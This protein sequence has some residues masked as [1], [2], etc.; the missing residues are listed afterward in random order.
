MEKNEGKRLA[1]RR[2][3][4]PEEFIDWSIL[5]YEDKDTSD[6]D[7]VEEPA[8]R[9]IYKEKQKWLPFENPD[10]Q[11]IKDLVINSEENVPQK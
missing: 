2:E 8:A 6:E 3:I 1:Q 7:D 10:Q 9:W 11:I 5:S 4:Q